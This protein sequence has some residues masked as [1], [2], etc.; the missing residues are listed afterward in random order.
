MTASKKTTV[1]IDRELM[2]KVKMVAIEYGMPYSAVVEILICEA[3]KDDTIR[4]TINFCLEE[5]Q[6]LSD[7]TE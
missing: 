2:Q 5:A 7:N 3:F 4:T 6:I 1:Q